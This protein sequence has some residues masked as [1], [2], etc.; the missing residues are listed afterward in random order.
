[1]SDRSRFKSPDM[2]RPVDVVAQ[3]QLVMPGATVKG[4]Q[5]QAL[6]DECKRKGRPLERRKYQS[7]L[8][9]P[10]E[11]VLVLA[12]AAALVWPDEPAREGLRR[13]GRVAYPTLKS[14]LIGRVVFGAVGADVRLL[15]PLVSKGYQLSA[16]RGH[17]ELLELEGREAVVRLKDIF[18]FLDAW[19]VGILEGA[20]L[21]YGQEAE[22]LFSPLSETSGDFLIRW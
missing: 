21:A 16:S 10:G 3:Q 17:A 1:M 22:V 4:M 15:W 2:K 5:L 8:D 7:F 20:M 6:L 19:H 12:Q 13:L 14:S 18:S 11:L 9:Y